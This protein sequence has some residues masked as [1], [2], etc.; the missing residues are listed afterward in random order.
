D[1]GSGV[2][3]IVVERAVGQGADALRPPA[4]TEIHLDVGLFDDVVA[5]QSPDICQ[6]LIRH[7]LI[8]PTPQLVFA[9]DRDTTALRPGPRK[10]VAA[11]RGH[12]AERIV[13]IMDAQADLLEIVAAL[14]AAR[15]LAR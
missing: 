8:E 14:H 3:D 2:A 1:S 10:A 13:M 5:V 7:N 9:G 12:I 6:L 11:G 15:R 4:G